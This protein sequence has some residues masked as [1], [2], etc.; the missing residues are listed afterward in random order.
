MLV[1]VHLETD[2]PL[3]FLCDHLE[4]MLVYGPVNEAYHNFLASWAHT[5]VTRYLRNGE[6]KISSYQLHDSLK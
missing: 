5:L 4:S 3:G 1:H 6:S 2:P